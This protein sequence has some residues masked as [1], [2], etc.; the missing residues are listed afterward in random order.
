MFD[1]LEMNINFKDMKR[2][3]LIALSTVVVLS[4][5]YAS[6]GV[7]STQTNGS[8]FTYRK[9]KNNAFQP[10]EKLTYRLH[11]GIIDAAI[12]TLEVKSTDKK[13]KERELLHVVAKGKSIGSFNWFFK[14][15]DHYE[16]YID[17]E[18]LFPWVFIRRVNEGGYKINQNYTFIQNKGKVKEGDK[19]YKAP[20]NVQDMISSY[21]YARTLDFSNAQEGDIFEFESFVDGEVYPLKI[22]F[23]GRE[24][25]KLKQG[26]FRALKFC[27]V[28]QVDRIFKDE[29]D[30]T[31]WIS[32]DENK[33][34][35][36]AKA[37]ILVGSI[38]ME[39]IDY[40]G[41]KNPISKK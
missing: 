5:G 32:D 27:P 8:A 24:T 40:E 13:I 28:V 11:Y 17:A 35:L 12:A 31:V 3:I 22:K 14:V 23:L 33:I 19:E 38:K 10:G 18:S 1:S 9:I 16:S 21:Y 20:Y 34:P 36:M 6:D 15:D 37:S 39:L 29:D 26:K 7:Y 4:S 41:I 30:L 2:L 25:I